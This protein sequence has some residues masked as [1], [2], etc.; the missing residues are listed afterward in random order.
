[1]TH[2]EI[3][4]VDDIL[5]K[6]RKH[7]LIQKKKLATFMLCNS[8]VYIAFKEDKIETVSCQPYSN[9]HNMIMKNWII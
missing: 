8:A 3:N 1:M 6:R 9:V 5:G 4:E 7:S 2:C